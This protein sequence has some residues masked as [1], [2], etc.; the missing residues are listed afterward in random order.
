MPLYLYRCLGCNGWDQRV[1]G[2]DDHTAI[3][4][5]CGGVMLREDQDVFRPYFGPG[6]EP[7][8]QATATRPTPSRENGQGSGAETDEPLESHRPHRLR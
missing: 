7:D 6:P 4:T 1:A 8:G 5:E 3:C 2:L